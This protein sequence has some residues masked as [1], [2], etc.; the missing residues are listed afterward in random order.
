MAEG[1]VRTLLERA[2]PRYI[3][4]TEQQVEQYLA[5]IVRPLLALNKEL[6]GVKAEINV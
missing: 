2:V 5:Q 3:R 1:A 6:L 4:E